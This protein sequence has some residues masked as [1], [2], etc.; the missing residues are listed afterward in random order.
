MNFFLFYPTCTGW[1][2]ITINSFFSGFSTGTSTITSCHFF[3][4]G[5][6]F[7][8]CSTVSCAFTPWTP[9][10]Q[11][12]IHYDTKRKCSFI[13]LKF[14]SDVRLCFT[15]ANITVR[16]GASFHLG[17][18]SHTRGSASSSCCLIP[19]SHPYGRVTTCWAC[20]PFWPFMPDTILS[21][22]IK[23]SCYNDSLV[24]LIKVHTW[25]SR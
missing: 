5:P 19:G 22:W 17:W 8:G 23:M 6:S 21:I 3:N 11:L 12:A 18:W 15:W 7:C 1:G 20:C 9:L 2:Y 16:I 14:K 10:W 24:S 4:S 25:T 13:K